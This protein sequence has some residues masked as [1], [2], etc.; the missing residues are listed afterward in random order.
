MCQLWIV[1]IKESYNVSFLNIFCGCPSLVF[2]YKNK[3]PYK[4]KPQQRQKPNFRIQGKL[5]LSFQIDGLWRSHQIL[6]ETSE[7]QLS[8]CGCRL[9]VSDILRYSQHV[10]SASAPLLVMMVCWH[11]GHLPLGIIGNP[12]SQFIAKFYFNGGEAEE[13]FKT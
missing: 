12:V 2:I 11:V 5:M 3:R 4:Q 8:S 13:H 10:L 7:F 1:H 9:H 6:S